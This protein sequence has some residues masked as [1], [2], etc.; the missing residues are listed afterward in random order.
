[1]KNISIAVYLFNKYS[2]NVE[3]LTKA[4][5]SRLATLSKPSSQFKYKI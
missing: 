3:V 2:Y 1:M 5:E 4:E